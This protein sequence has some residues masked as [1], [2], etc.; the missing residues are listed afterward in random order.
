MMNLPALLTP[1]APRS[2]ASSLSELPFGSQAQ[3]R[4]KDGQLAAFLAYVGY[5]RSLGTVKYALRVLNNTPF[6]AHAR[7]L[8]DVQGSLL[9]AYPREFDVAP[10]SMRDDIIPVRMDVTGPFDR[11]IVEVLTEESS[12]TVEAPPPPR[13]RPRWAPWTAL[14][15]IP[16]FALGATQ[17]AT[18]RILDVTAPQKA[19]AGSSIRV[20][21]QVSGFGS[22]EYDFE[23]RDGL[24][25]A[26]GLASGSGVLTL[27]LP[28]DGMG[29]PYTLHVRMRNALTKA[30]EQASIAAVVPRVQKVKP[31]A[32]GTPLIENLAV[33]PSPAIAGK[34]ISVRYATQ[35]PSGEVWLVDD[36]GATWAH[37]AVSRNGET[38]LVIPPAAAGKQMRVVLHAQSG[39]AHA[40]S[41]VGIAITAPLQQ[42]AQPQQQTVAAAAPGAQQ[43]S[44]SESTAA[45]ATDLTLSS[46]VVSAGDTVTARITGTHGDIRITLM[47]TAGT[48]L[49]EGDT[50]DT[51]AV[52]LN[53]PAVTTPTTFFVVATL[54]SGV[55]QQSIVKRLVVTPR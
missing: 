46:Q 52:S 36:L 40:E 5:E 1:A 16:V 50:G 26:A 25:L 37:G 45:T 15:A 4:V 34:S 44:T 21:Y 3:V 54:T 9:S 51:D 20:P 42:Q 33:S 23:T 18:P 32:P 22:V 7:L 53:A 8:V 14:A 17:F 31:S 41:S 47:N 19:I 35:A 27:Q 13:E 12:F 30:E 24:Q 38:Q 10:F 55:S 6:T 2:I 49:S 29:S 48:T 11:A 39:G 28:H 43:S